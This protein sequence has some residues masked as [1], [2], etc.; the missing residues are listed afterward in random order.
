MGNSEANYLA[1]GQYGAVGIILAAILGMALWM[2]RA[3]FTRLIE[4]FDSSHKFQTKQTE[5]MVSMQHEIKEVRETMKDQHV[6][7]LE[8]LEMR[9]TPVQGMR[10]QRDKNER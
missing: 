6:D 8:R 5:V 10:A 7:L 2:S 9:R 3:L 4:F 1:L